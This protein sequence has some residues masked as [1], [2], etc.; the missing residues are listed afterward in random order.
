MSGI[1]DSV[2]LNEGINKSLDCHFPEITDAYSSIDALPWTA[3]RASVANMLNSLDIGQTRA[4]S[5]DC[6]R[7]ERQRTRPPS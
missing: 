3:A 5:K 1:Q 6:S 2:L 4:S 7:V